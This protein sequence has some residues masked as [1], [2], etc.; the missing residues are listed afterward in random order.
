MVWWFGGDRERVKEKN[1]CVQKRDLG[2]SD[3][4]VADDSLR[5]GRYNF[6]YKDFIEDEATAGVMG[7][8]DVAEGI[9][10]HDGVRI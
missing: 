4:D 3:G 2:L 1:E 5:L 8:V 6:C 10:L 9:A 7:W